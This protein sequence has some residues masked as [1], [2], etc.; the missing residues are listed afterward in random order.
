MKDFWINLPDNLI[1]MAFVS[2]I[3]YIVGMTTYIEYYPP[4]NS[5]RN[6]R[7]NIPTEYPRDKLLAIY[8]YQFFHSYNCD[9]C[10]NFNFPACE[11]SID[12]INSILEQNT[13]D[14]NY[15]LLKPES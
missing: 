5:H 11:H 14:E 3:L 2:M 7:A 13:I 8:F 10:S 9:K 1:G 12:A 6:P 4:V 15:V